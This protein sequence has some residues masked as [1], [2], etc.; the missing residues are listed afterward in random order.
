MSGTS[1]NDTVCSCNADKGYIPVN[2][3]KHYGQH[4]KDECSY[5]NITTERGLYPLL[6]F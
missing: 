6:T 5:S 4:S 2:V 3:T 1:V